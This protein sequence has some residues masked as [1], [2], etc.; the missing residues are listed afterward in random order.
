M[1]DI[2]NRYNAALT[3]CFPSMEKTDVLLQESKF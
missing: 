1:N 3:N 2:V